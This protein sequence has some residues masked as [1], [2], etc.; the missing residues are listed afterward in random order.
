V[1]V[2]ADI[3]GYFDYGSA[4]GELFHPVNP[5]RVLDDRTGTGLSGPWG[6]G[7]AR[8]LPLAGGAA[9]PTGAGA[10]LGNVTATNGT[11]GSY[12][13]TFPAASAPPGTSTLAFGAHQTIPTA[14]VAGLGGGG[15]SIANHLGTVDVVLDIN[16]YFAAP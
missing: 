9:I 6:P 8:T 11:T 14:F 5:T 13:T 16:G 15:L 2:V 1:H 10:V 12:L 7:V 3:V 4:G